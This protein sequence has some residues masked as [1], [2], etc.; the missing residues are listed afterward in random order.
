MLQRISI[1]EY[2]SFPGV[3]WRLKDPATRL[4]LKITGRPKAHT[5]Q[6]Y[7]TW[8][9][10][11]YARC[12]RLF[13]GEFPAD[14]LVNPEADPL[15]VHLA[16]GITALQRLGMQPVRRAQV[17]EAAGDQIVLALPSFHEAVLSTAIRLAIQLL[18]E[19]DALEEGA[20]ALPQ[21]LGQDLE[22]FL[23]QAPELSRCG[24]NQLYVALAAD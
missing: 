7:R 23:A 21:Q 1:Q 2:V 6:R 9:D 10:Q 19:L 13:E 15:A 20:G 8:F 16:A 5:F 4:V 18:L 3:R 14:W 12:F 22:E 17:L 11:R 24:A